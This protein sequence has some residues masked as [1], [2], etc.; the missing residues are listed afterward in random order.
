[1]NLGKKL[2]IVIFSVLIVLQFFQPTLPEVTLD[3]PNDILLNNDIP[4][5][6]EEIIKNSCYDCHSNTTNYPWYSHISPSSFLVVRDIKKGRED[7][8]FSNWE[9]LN[10]IEKAGAIDDIVGVIEEEEMPMQIYTV[11]HQNAKLTPS[12]RER[13][14]SWAEEYSEKL[15]D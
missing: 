13:L 3:N 10:K 14:I 9:E 8:N 12:D 7:L 1:M 6:I 4:K 2:A 15:F 11:I 5:D